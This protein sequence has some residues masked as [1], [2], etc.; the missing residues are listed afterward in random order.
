M[1]QWI[2]SLLDR[3]FP[4][5]LIGF[6][7][8][9][10][11]HRPTVLGLKN[12]LYVSHYF[13]ERDGACYLAAAGSYLAIESSTDQIVRFDP[14]TYEPE[15]AY[16][17][18]SLVGPEDTVIDVGANVGLHTVALA[19]AA[20]K[21]HVYAF[22]PVAEMAE[23]ASLNLALNGLENVNLFDCALG[24]E[25]GEAEII[26]NIAG[27]GM[28]GT[29]SILK[30]VHVEKRPGHYQPRTV[31][32]RRLDD[33]IAEVKPKRRISFIKI[34]TEGFEP[35]VIRGG[36]ETIRQHRPAMIVEAHSKRLAQV[37]LSFQW[38]LETF[39]DYHVLLSY[40]T[41]PANPYFRLQPLGAEP[42]EIA[43][44]LLLLPDQTGPGKA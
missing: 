26:V 12:P 40:E 39:A 6:L 7:F 35:M 23:R 25:T 34:D 22:E 8:G 44:N 41:T 42:P 21:G 3:P 31:S 17:I 29:S 36:M 5:A 24:E 38:Y 19:Q 20:H 2:L 11:R 15:I 33:V 9:F 14:G 13:I 4:G 1:K 28:E 30:T 10:L 16:L 18:Q 37:G 32:V 43:V 27:D